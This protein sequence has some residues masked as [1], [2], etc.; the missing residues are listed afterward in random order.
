MLHLFLHADESGSV[1]RELSL[2]LRHVVPW[3]ALHIAQMQKTQAKP[4]SFAGVRQ[5]C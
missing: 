1:A 4:P 3:M 5:A 2:G